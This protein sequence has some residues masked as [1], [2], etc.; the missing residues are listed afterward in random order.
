MNSLFRIYDKAKAE[1]NTDVLKR[2]ALVLKKIS[3][4]DCKPDILLHLVQDNNYKK[5]I[6]CLQLLESESKAAKN[7]LEIFE[8]QVK[9]NNIFNIKDK[10]IIDTINIQYRIMFLSEYVFSD[11]FSNL[12]LSE[13]NTYLSLHGNTV[14]CYFMKYMSSLFESLADLL[15]SQTRSISNFFHELFMILKLSMNDL[16]E[17]F[18]KVFVEHKFH[19]T[20]LDVLLSQIELL[21]NQDS[22]SDANFVILTCLEILTFVIKNQTSVIS[23]IFWKKLDHTKCLMDKLPVLVLNSNIN[24]VDLLLD[25]LQVNFM[26]RMEVPSDFIQFIANQLIPTLAKKVRQM[27]LENQLKSPRS[28]NEYQLKL[29]NDDKYNSEATSQKQMS[30]LKDHDRKLAKAHSIQESEL[31]IKSES[32]SKCEKDCVSVASSA[33]FLRR[34]NNEPVSL[35]RRDSQ[36]LRFLEF[37]IE[38]FNLLFELKVRDINEVL[39]EENIIDQISRLVLQTKSKS[40][41]ILF[42]KYFKNL[43]DSNNQLQKGLFFNFDS[44]VCSLWYVF[45]GNFR[46]MYQ[47]LTYSLCMAAFNSIRNSIDKNMFMILG[48]LIGKS[49]GLKA[50]DK[51]IQHLYAEFS[52]LKFPIDMDNFASESEISI[53]KSESYGHRKE[54]LN[55]CED[56]FLMMDAHNPRSPIQKPKQALTDEKKQSLKNLI[57]E[58]KKE[59]EKKEKEEDDWK[60]Y[61]TK[62]RQTA[63]SKPSIIIDVDNL[64][65]KRED[66][67]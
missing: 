45:T 59:K 42:V 18:C 37:V 38:M 48:H 52:A 15:V 13:I 63:E 20:V 54:K 5:F 40:F 31:I 24:I 64:L 22:D 7:Y 34:T 61:Q 35:G 44:S 3:L 65:E 25:I 2:L 41:K 27:S 66:H 23:T 19:L 16:K 49:E 60:A 56:P 62:S 17:T 33:T 10:I 9:F 11:V 57:S 50:K 6:E 39:I 14:I 30:Q 32:E 67:K 53:I 36:L 29:T 21:K 55:I 28:K 46:P 26:M 12:Q 1:N 8:S 58:M 47:N 43:V 51:M 4:L